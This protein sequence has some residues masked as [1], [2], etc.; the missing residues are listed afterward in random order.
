LKALVWQ[1]ADGTV[2]LTYDAPSWVAN[3]HGIGGKLDHTIE[4]LTTVAAPRPAPDP[5]P[6]A[7]P[8]GG[9][10]HVIAETPWPRTLVFSF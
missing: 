2:N 4:V 7:N 5:A 9:A 8:I 10:P 1:A 6:H 3:R